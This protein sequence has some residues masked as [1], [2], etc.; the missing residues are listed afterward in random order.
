MQKIAILY[1]TSQVVLST[2]DLDKVL[3]GILQVL[4]DYFNVTRSAVLLLD[5]KTRQL[6]ARCHSGWPAESQEF[7]IPLGVGIIGT[8]AQKKRP[9]YAPNVSADPHYVMTIPSTRSELAIPLMVRDEVV[10]VLDLQ[11]DDLNCFDPETIDLLTL[12]ST[13]A[14]IGLQNARLYSLEQRRAAQL[15]AINRIGRETTAVLDVREL[16]Q[17]VCRVTREAFNLDH[18]AVLLLEEERLIFRAHD[19]VLTP[20][21]AV[22]TELP[23]GS[24]LCSQVLES[25]K[26]VLENDVASVPGYMPGFMETRSEMCIP[27]ISFGEMLGVITLES[28]RA[29]AFQEADTQ[30][31][32]SVADMCANAIQNA[33]YLERFKQLA[34]VDGLTGIF[35]RRFFE[36]EIRDEIERVSR[37][38]NTFAVLMIDIDQFKRLNDEFGHLLGDEVLRQISMIFKQ[39]V[40]KIDRV[41]RYGGEEFAILLPQ[42]PLGGA[43]LVAEKLRR[44]VER[45]QFPGV[46]R[47]VTISVGIAECPLNGRGRDDVVRAA[48][49]AL[50]IAKQSGRNR[51]VKA[52]STKSA[53]G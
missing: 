29:D 47:S 4:R 10:G 22:E 43:S 5:P 17:K 34:Y 44:V 15:E 35:N 48:D 20:S 21:I 41:F 38:E 16:M 26:P 19:G 13:Q 28:A 2:F 23:P 3:S 8:A 52:P 39:H 24:G 9:I 51:A 33:R 53:S 11:S 7:A 40:R 37:Y 30:P 1:D 49:T 12:F 42:T 27:L 25:G 31:L 6:T 14:S 50:Y 45:W 46:P 36:M 32:E 18:V